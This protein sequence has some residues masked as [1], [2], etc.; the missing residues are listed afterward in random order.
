[1]S[2]PHTRPFCFCN[3]VMHSEDFYWIHKS[4]RE[5]CISLKPCG[6]AGASAVRA[7][8]CAHTCT[9]PY[10]HAHTRGV[11]RRAGVTPRGDHRLGTFHSWRRVSWRVNHTH[12]PCRDLLYC[13]PRWLHRLSPPH[14]S[15]LRPPLSSS[16]CTKLP[17]LRQNKFFHWKHSWKHLHLR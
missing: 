14:R 11:C 3:P 2:T 6:G 12:H 15:R 8:T 5:N 16:W 4:L 1:M 17:L 13:R 7:H 9:H 10:T